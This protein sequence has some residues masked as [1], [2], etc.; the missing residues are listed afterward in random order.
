MALNYFVGQ[1]PPPQS[2]QIT[3]V[4]PHGSTG[5]TGLGAMVLYASSPEPIATLPPVQVGSGRSS[6][7]PDFVVPYTTVAHGTLPAVPVGVGVSYGSMPNP[8]LNSHLQHN[9][10]NPL[11]Q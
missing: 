6:E 7:V 10:P 1:T 4:R 11:V 2:D 8:Q 9:A 5:Q 3:P